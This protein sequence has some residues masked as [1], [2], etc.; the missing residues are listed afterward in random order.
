MNFKMVLRIQSYILVILAILMIPSLGITI[1]TQDG[2]AMTG[3]LVGIAAAAI[4]GGVGLIVTKQADR[5]YYAR[6][7]MLTTGLAW[8]VMSAIGCL[9]FFVSGRIPNYIDAFFEMVSGFTTTGASI[10]TDVEALGKGLLFWRSFSHWIGGMGILVFFLAIIPVSGKN[11]GFTLHI[12]RAE[13]P[14]PSVNK[15]VPRMRYTA[16]ILYILYCVLTV[17][18]I[19]FLLIGDMPVYDAFCIAFGTAGT[20]GFAVLNSGLATYTPFAQWVT[21]VFMLAFGVNF[22]LYYLIV[23]KRFAAAVKDE[24][25]RMY[26]SIVLISITL[27]ALNIFGKTVDTQNLEPTLR[28]AAF[29]VASIITTTGYSTVDFNLW[30]S[31]SRTIIVFLMFLGASAGSTGG[32]IKNVRVLL[33]LKSLKRNAKQIFHPHEVRVVRLNGSRVSEQTLANTNSY[34]V[35]YVAIIIISVLAISFD[36]GNFSFETN[37]TAIMATFNNIG[38]GLDQVGPTQNFSIYNNFSTLLMSFDMLLGRLEIFPIL[39]IFTPAL[40]K[41]N[42]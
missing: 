32:G 24:E 38:P 22:G 30:P 27:I 36:S 15:M 9:P 3:F 21:T 14:G 17:L 26:L 29:Q 12:L 18:D 1:F 35:C 39:A 40:Y 42:H 8:V 34:L 37:F 19:I 7:G 11:S 41:K 28:H 4:L 25:L 20:G 16:G 10:L 2:P 23:V 33:L 13:S 6:E 31:F 5:R